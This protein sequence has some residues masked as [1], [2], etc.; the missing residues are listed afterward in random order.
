MRERGHLENPG[1]DWRI[2]L[3]YGRS[4]IRMMGTWTELLWHRWWAH[5]NAVTNLRVP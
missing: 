4:S 5:V 3:K 1:I 2:I